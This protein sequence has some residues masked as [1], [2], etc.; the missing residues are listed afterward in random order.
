M[1]PPLRFLIQFAGLDAAGATLAAH[2]LRSTLQDADPGISATIPPGDPAAMSSGFEL[3][4]TLL[5]TGS[6]VAL[7]KGVGDWL[8]RA[9]NSSV[10]VTRP[11]GTKLE[12]RN[13][14]DRQAT[15]LAKAIL[16]A[17]TKD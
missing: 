15:D 9:P 3:L 8:R 6:V 12:V 16:A 13:V 17:G 4:V 10:I 14:Y 1:E 11:D 5:G 7:A 2:E